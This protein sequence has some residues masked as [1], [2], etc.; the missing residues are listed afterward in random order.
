MAPPSISLGSGTRSF[1]CTTREQVLDI[2]PQKA[3]TR[4]NAP[5]TADAVVYWKIVDP[6]LARYAVA[7]LV[8]AI[9]E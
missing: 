4:D 3:I 6:E 8:P 7:E 9:R 5:L 1:D 2:P